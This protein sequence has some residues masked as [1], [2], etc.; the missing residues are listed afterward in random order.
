MKNKLYQ[1]T[2]GLGTFWIIAT[3]PTTAQNRLKEELDKADYGFSDNRVVTEIRLIT[4]AMHEFPTGKLHFSSIQQ[5]L[6]IC[7]SEEK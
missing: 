3:D 1:L 4:E 2:S 6:I 5:K 7:K